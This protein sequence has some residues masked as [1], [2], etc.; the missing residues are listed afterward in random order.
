MQKLLSDWIRELFCRNT[1]LRESEQEVIKNTR[2]SLLVKE[3]RIRLVNTEIIWHRVHESCPRKAGRNQRTIHRPEWRRWEAESHL[4]RR[5]S[6]LSLYWF[7]VPWACPPWAVN[8][9][10]KS[11]KEIYV[12]MLDTEN[13][14]HRLCL[15]KHLRSFYVLPSMYAGKSEENW[16]PWLKIVFEGPFHSVTI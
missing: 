2:K 4:G 14:Q 16:W 15:P 13:F 12:A 1:C 5:A 3:S 6:E 8:A 9:A 11:K 10:Q 7:R